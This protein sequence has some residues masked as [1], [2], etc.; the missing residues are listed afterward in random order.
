VFTLSQPAVVFNSVSKAFG[1]TQALENVS[2]EI[3]QG[4]VFGY[5]GPNGAGKTTTIKILVGLIQDFDGEVLVDGQSVSKERLNIHRKLGYLP[6]EVGFQ[7][8]RTVRQMLT[9]FGRLSGLSRSEI[10]TR[11]SEVL[12]TVG[13]PDVENRKIAHLSGGMK[14]KL[15][16]AQCLLHQPELLVLDEPMS[17][18][19][20]A[21]R[22]QVRLIIRNLC[23][24]GVTVLFSSHILSDVQDIA[25]QVGILNNGQLLVVGTPDQIQNHFQLGNDIEVV[26]A[27]GSSICKNFA[28]LPTIESTEEL[29]LNRILLHL[30][31]EADI[32][33][34]IP[35]ILEKLISEGCKLRSFNLVRPS[36]EEVYLKYVE[37]L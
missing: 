12:E 24:K 34:V 36:L 21:S 18:L 35:N 10:N 5:I 30:K 4:S 25:T 37:G 31:P 17:G 22:H 20:P 15:H 27:E 23:Q 7:E 13:L 26:V 6:Q 19:D 1:N 29:S 2:F 11:V 16:L 32:D 3:P 33:R 14:Q 8:W 9:T 28:E